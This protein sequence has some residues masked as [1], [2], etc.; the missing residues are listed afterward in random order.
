MPLTGPSRRR[1]AGGS[2]VAR[3]HGA[4]NGSPE[5]ILGLL[6]PRLVAVRWIALAGL[7]TWGV[8]GL[9]GAVP[10]L[11]SSLTGA[12]GRLA[13]IPKERHLTLMCQGGY[14]GTIAAS[15][16]LN[17]GYHDLENVT[18]GYGDYVAAS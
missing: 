17:A 6:V 13:E 12:A 1:V 4:T 16:L 18:G 10:K 11:G 8:C 15:L 5:A 14:R 9:L 7:V 2:R 3:L